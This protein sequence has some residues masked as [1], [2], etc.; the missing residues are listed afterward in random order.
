VYEHNYSDKLK[1]FPRIDQSSRRRVRL[2]T[3]YRSSIVL[4]AF[5]HCGP[6]NSATFIFA[7]SSIATRKLLIW[8][9]S[10]GVTSIDHDITYVSAEGSHFELVISTHSLAVFDCFMWLAC[11]YFVANI[12]KKCWYSLQ[13]ILS[14]SAATQLRR[15]GRIYSTDVRWSFLI[16]MVK[17]SLKSL[18]RYQRFCKNNSGTVCWNT[19]YFVLSLINSK[20]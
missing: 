6:K 3:C 10:T 19:V 2:A 8:Q 16:V 1:R 11:L 20:F 13:N 7:I 9:W 18:N 5:L 15:G 17:E 12:Y 14:G 4:P